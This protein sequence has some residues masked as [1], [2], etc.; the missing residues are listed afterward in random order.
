MASAECGGDGD[1]W[2]RLLDGVPLLA[3]LVVDIAGAMLLAF[4]RARRPRSL[5]SFGQMVYCSWFL[6]LLPAHLT[7]RLVLSVGNFLARFHRAARAEFTRRRPPA[8]KEEGAKESGLEAGG[9]GAAADPAAAAAAA[10]DGAADADG[11]AG[12]FAAAAHAA[13]A[14]LS[15]A[16]LGGPP[17]EVEF[18][19]Q[20]VV[21]Q[22]LVLLGLLA[23]L[24]FLLLALGTIAPGR[25]W[26]VALAFLALWLTFCVC[27]PLFATWP[28]LFGRGAAALGLGELLPSCFRGDASHLLFVHYALGL[29]PK[30]AD[31]VRAREAGCSARLRAELHAMVRPWLSQ[32]LASREVRCIVEAF[33][34]AAPSLQATSDAKSGIE[35]S[36]AFEELQTLL[37]AL[38]GVFADGFGEA[39]EA[40]DAR[41]DVLEELL[42]WEEVWRPAALKGG[43]AALDIILDL[44]AQPPWFAADAAV[45]ECASAA[46]AS[47]AAGRI[48]A[49]DAESVGRLLRAATATATTSAA[50]WHSASARALEAVA[51]GFG[52]DRVWAP[53]ANSGNAPLLR[54]LSR[55][56]LAPTKAVLT[57]GVAAGSSLEAIAFLLRAGTPATAP[58]RPLPAAEGLGDLLTWEGHWRQVVLAPAGAGAEVVSHLVGAGVLPTTVAV[59]SAIREDAPEDILRLLIDALQSVP[60][61]AMTLGAG[62]SWEDTWQRLLEEESGL[63]RMKFLC[64]AGVAPTKHVVKAAIRAQSPPEAL[65]MICRS[66]KERYGSI[67]DVG[68]ALGWEDAWHSLVTTSGGGRTLQL[69]AEHCIAPSAIVVEA[70]T[71]ASVVRP[72]MSPDGRPALS[73]E[74][75]G[76]ILA[77]GYRR[78]GTRG[79]GARLEWEVWEPAARHGDS[80]WIAKLCEYDIR[81][82]QAIIEAMVRIRAPLACLR[83]V[84]QPGGEGGRFEDLGGPVSEATWLSIFQD[85]RQ[86][87]PEVARLVLACAAR[88]PAAR[89]FAAAIGALANPKVVA[90]AG[91]YVENLALPR[92]VWMQLLHLVSEADASAAARAT[93]AEEAEAEVEAQT[94]VAA[95][96]AKSDRAGSATEAEPADAEACAEESQSPSAAASAS[97]S[98]SAEQCAEDKHSRALALLELSLRLCKKRLQEEQELVDALWVAAVKGSS[99]AALRL[100]RELDL[101]MACSPRGGEGG[102]VPR[103]LPPRS[104]S[105]G[106]LTDS[107]SEVLVAK[108]RD[109]LSFE[110]SVPRLAGPGGAESVPP[111]AGAG[112]RGI[113]RPGP[114]REPSVRPSEEDEATSLLPPES[115]AASSLSSCSAAAPESSA[116]SRWREAPMA[117]QSPTFGP[118]SSEDTTPSRQPSSTLESCGKLASGL[119]PGPWRSLM[120]PTTLPGFEAPAPQPAV[121][122]PAPPPVATP[123]AT[124]RSLLAE[125]ARPVTV[126]GAAPARLHQQVID[127]LVRCPEVRAYLERTC[128]DDRWAPARAAA[129][130]GEGGGGTSRGLLQ[131]ETAK[132][133]A[134]RLLGREALRSQGKPIVASRLLA[135]IAA[136]AANDISCAS[137]AP[138]AEFPLPEPLPDLPRLLASG[139]GAAGCESDEGPGEPALLALAPFEGVWKRAKDPNGEGFLIT[140]GRLL[141]PPKASDHGSGRPRESRL[142]LCANGE[143]E[144][145]CEGARSM[146]GTVEKDLGRPDL[147]KLVW[148]DGDIWLR[149]KLGGE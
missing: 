106:P 107:G 148:D 5:T 123:R 138:G 38:S 133:I 9:G 109:G 90:L 95:Q 30:A 31:L 122:P 64:D 19:A 25:A 2:C 145:L 4:L 47:N 76:R 119:P 68:G 13:A 41:K 71:R 8:A 46:L 125:A 73:L 39:P 50:P 6:L 51:E 55:S 40:K 65:E 61:R 134:A 115:A 113:C 36:E 26:G 57:E 54:E 17:A 132:D 136:S 83:P 137:L 32:D 72:L 78:G 34:A 92:A 99:P 56:G 29:H 147:L 116:P 18:V 128:L 146:R 80:E 98:P 10:D 81:P 70:A 21:P 20:W 97:A 89:T 140:S 91:E 69:L 102:P 141:W 52:W 45:A 127:E 124:P 53:I 48:E 101:P 129:A 23:E 111:W 118:F 114:Q 84:L 60:E 112:S 110:V 59:E 63:Q 104:P 62:L 96:E 27:N 108:R 66:A 93:A 16:V 144:V 139:A 49:I 77:A 94:A 143:L 14:G 1:V 88:A 11:R 44:G 100:L 79:V 15:A 35:E 86:E 28:G 43:V 7:F 37:G 58:S 126:N 105:K 117:F 12:V 24:L 87:A 3:W 22:L 130:E 120:V 75:L 85:E 131:V 67:A 42:T 103:H 82:S 142:R 74:A 33:C 121:A 135:D 149:A